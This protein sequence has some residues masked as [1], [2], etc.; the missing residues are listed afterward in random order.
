[1]SNRPA[2]ILPCAA[3]VTL[4][5]DMSLSKRVFCLFGMYIGVPALPNYLNDV[6]NWFV[7]LSSPLSLSTAVTSRCSPRALT[8]QE[9]LENALS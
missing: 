7:P 5:S 4:P 8:T 2:V 9:Q 3:C 6:N 1:V